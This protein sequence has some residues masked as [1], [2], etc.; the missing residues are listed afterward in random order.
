MN[1]L[2]KILVAL[3]V[4]SSVLLAFDSSNFELR[5]HYEQPQ[6]PE[7]RGFPVWSDGRGLTIEGALRLSGSTTLAL[8]SSYLDYSFNDKQPPSVDGGYYSTEASYIKFAAM[9]RSTLLKAGRVT[10]FVNPYVTSGIG[11][12]FEDFQVEGWSWGDPFTRQRSR[13]N[14]YII[15]GGGAEFLSSNN[16]SVFI[17][18]GIENPIKGM[19]ES[20]FWLPFD[21]ELTFYGWRY[22]LRYR[23]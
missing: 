1:T 12:M 6:H 10:S 22:G 15:I 8:S 18:Y 19:A 16:T 9:I 4:S 23:F 7:D 17:D 14:L 20:G 13:D 11:L 21:D 2:T 3:F 5:M